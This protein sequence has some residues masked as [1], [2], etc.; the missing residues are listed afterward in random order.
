M[1]GFYGIGVFHLKTRSN[2]GTLWRSAYALGASFIFT[3]GRRYEVQPSDT[4]KTLR[5]LPYYRYATLADFITRMP[6]KTQLVGVEITDDAISLP[7]FYH[8]T[9]TV[10]LLGAED[11]GLTEEAMLSCDRIISIPSSVC[12]NV[13]VA[14]SIVMYDRVAKYENHNT[15]RYR[16]FVREHNLS[17]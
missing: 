1:R 12:L 2:L 13:S 10:Y 15:M 11:Y 4:T 7:T 17:V 14:G 9:R 8:P 16:D 3:I 5:H 6:E